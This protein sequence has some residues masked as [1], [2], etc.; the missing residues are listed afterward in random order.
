MSERFTI[1]NFES[2]P[3]NQLTFYTSAEFQAIHEDQAKTAV[4]F[5]QMD[6]M[7]PAFMC[8]VRFV[9]S[10]DTMAVRL[11]P[12]PKLNL[13][14]P[15]IVP[16]IVSQMSVLDSHTLADVTRAANDFL[17]DRRNAQLADESRTYVS[18]HVLA[19]H[20]L[21]TIDLDRVDCVSLCAF[22]ADMSIDWKATGRWKNL[23][24]L[25]SAPFLDA[26]AQSNF[27]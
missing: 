24:E 22:A 20:I 13:L 8:G 4:A 3:T 2:E 7:R 1:G 19:Q 6:R 16:P 15:F 17:H 26:L 12:H 14:L 27:L 11:S 18:A 10:V 23:V 5:G 9:G 25:G 21:P